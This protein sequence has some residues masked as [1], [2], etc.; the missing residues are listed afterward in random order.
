MNRDFP[1]QSSIGVRENRKLFRIGY[2]LICTPL[3]I[4]LPL[5]LVWAV[6][7]NWVFET[8]FVNV[9][10]ETAFTV[11]EKYRVESATLDSFG[12]LW[13]IRYSSFM[14]VCALAVFCNYILLAQPTIYLAAR[15]GAPVTKEQSN[16]SLFGFF[17]LLLLIYLLFFHQSDAGVGRRTFLGQRL[18]GTWFVFPVFASLWSALGVV[19]GHL[20][21]IFTKLLNPYF[22]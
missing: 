5:S 17:I 22:R 12:A 15:H 13:G 18:F 19:M 16:A 6:L 20:T 10:Q 8:D 14:A 1:P 4:L 3:I 21:V 2:T 9:L 7:P 11:A